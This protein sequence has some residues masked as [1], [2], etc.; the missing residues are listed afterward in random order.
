MSDFTQSR[1]LHGD[2]GLHVLRIPVLLSQAVL[3]HDVYV[4]LDRPRGALPPEVMSPGS[5]G[6]DTG[7]VVPGAGQKSGHA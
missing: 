4:C 6:Q 7:H 1:P 3:A 2:I 5:Q